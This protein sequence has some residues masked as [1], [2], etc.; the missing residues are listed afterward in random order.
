ML[1]NASAAPSP[2]GVTA[3]DVTGAASY[4]V[5]V[6]RFAQ[7]EILRGGV[8]LSQTKIY[9]AGAAVIAPA[10]GT[11]DGGYYFRARLLTLG[12]APT[13]RVSQSALAAPELR[14]EAHWTTLAEFADDSE[15]AL[16][17][18]GYAGL[19]FLNG[20]VN[21]RL[22]RVRRYMDRRYA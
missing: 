6:N 14:N 10:L 18:P 3:A 9:P 15:D 4:Y 16:L 5:R 8:G 22:W 21:Q 1:R 17:A 11:V 13:F 2:S 19:V 12:G 7:I 20:G